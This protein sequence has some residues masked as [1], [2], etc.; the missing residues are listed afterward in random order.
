MKHVGG[1]KEEEGKC[2]SYKPFC[3]HSNNP[4]EVKSI[5]LKKRGNLLAE[6]FQFFG[7]TASLLAIEV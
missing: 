4:F 2:S 7:N 3:S 6:K 1:G 5:G